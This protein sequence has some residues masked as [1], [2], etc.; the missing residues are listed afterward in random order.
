MPP[1]FD[2][3]ICMFNDLTSPIAYLASRRSGK[4]REM[5]APGP[6]PHQLEAILNVAIRT[7]DHGKLFPWRILVIDDRA[8][9]AELFEK[10]FLKTN[11]DARQAQIDAVIAPVFMAPTLLILLHA[12][13][14]STKIPEWEQQLSSGAVAMNLLHAAHAAALSPA[15]SRAGPPMILWFQ[16]SF[17][18]MVSGLP[19]FSISDRPATLKKSARALIQIRSSDIGHEGPK[20]D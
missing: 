2:E 14:P 11:P 6:D 19:G 5:I 17:V 12:T 16:T 15:G 13:Q 3:A 1:F 10:A 18:Q 20:R 7:P 9:L 4:P 8:A